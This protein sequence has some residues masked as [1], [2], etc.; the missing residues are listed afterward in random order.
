MLL[1]AAPP[2]TEWEPPGI[3][4]LKLLTVGFLVL[5]NGFFVASEFA[6]V[7]VRGTQLDAREELVGEIQDEFDAEQPGFRRLDE[8]DFVISGALGLHEMR[9][10]AGIDLQHADVSTVSGYVPAALGHLP[11]KGEQV[12]IGGYRVTVAQAGTRRVR[13]LHF[14][15]LPEAGLVRED[16]G[17]P[18][19]CAMRS[20]PGACARNL[21]S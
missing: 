18:S 20:A 6:I 9:D 13:Q 7:K 16:G 8:N 19:S 15:K 14:H 3:I 2:A 12:T 21:R 4:L 11:K 1:A 17:R 10:V 5:L